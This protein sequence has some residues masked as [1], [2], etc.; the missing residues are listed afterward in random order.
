MTTKAGRLTSSDDALQRTL[1]QE[2][3]PLIGPEHLPKV[4]CYRSVS[5]FRQAMNRNTLPVRVF[6]VEG[7]KGKFAFSTDVAAWLEQLKSNGA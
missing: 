4:L 7:R 6:S 1:F 3:G 5:A 2:Y